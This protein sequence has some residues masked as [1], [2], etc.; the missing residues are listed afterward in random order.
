MSATQWE[1]EGNGDYDITD[2]NESIKSEFLPVVYEEEQEVISEREPQT[3]A[4][5]DAVTKQAFDL[6]AASFG[7]RR[8]LDEFDTLGSFI[9][10]NVRHWSL[11]NPN[12]GNRFRTRLYALVQEFQQEYCNSL[13]TGASTAHSQM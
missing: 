12:L 5:S 1:L 7:K 6:I 2:A 9:G 8:D 11:S 4:N 10:D 13:A 3:S